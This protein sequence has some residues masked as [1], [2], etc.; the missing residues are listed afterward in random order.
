MYQTKNKSYA[1]IAVFYYVLF[2]LGYLLMGILY[3]S[4]SKY[5]PAIQWVL[6]VI[7][8]LIV[9]I[10]DKSAVNLGFT[11][12]KIRSNLL[13]A[14]II[15]AISVSIAFLYTDRSAIVITKAV[16]Y[17]LFYIALQ[18]EMIFRGFVQNYLFGLS[19]DK[20]SV[21][22][23]GAVFFSL[24]HLPF[25]MFVNDAISFSYIIEALPQLLFTFLLHL[26]MCFITDK[27]KDILVPVALHFALNFL[28][29]VL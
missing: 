27:R 26:I 28:Q 29:E 12:E 2:M 1:I 14:A 20:K 21:F 7:A 25:Q 3:K 9:F 17:Y 23:I 6:L 10:K 15:V 13:I 24:A 22:I 8:V 5:Y 19:V 16:L 18:E 11:K 4:G